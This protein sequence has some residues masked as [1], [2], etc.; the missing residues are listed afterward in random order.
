MVVVIECQ[1]LLCVVNKSPSMCHFFFFLCH[2][3]ANLIS[4]N[5]VTNY[6]VICRQYGDLNLSA[7]SVG[8]GAQIT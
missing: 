3:R 2:A 8:N 4:V 1:L 5:I 7:P 6:G